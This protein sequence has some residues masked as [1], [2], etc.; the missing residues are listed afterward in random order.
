MT[1]K[2][3]YI[4]Y[5]L[6]TV[7]NSPGSEFKENYRLSKLVDSI[8]AIDDVMKVSYVVGKT[9]GLELLFK[10]LLYI[11]D[12]IDKSQVTIF[13]L[14]D[15]FEYDKIN[16]A[17]ICA[18]I[19]LYKSE[20]VQEAIKEI[21]EEKP[22]LRS[23]EHEKIT[24]EVKD[25]ITI[26]TTEKENVVN[27]VEMEEMETVESDEDSG[28]TGL[29]LIEN[30]ETY[31]GE[32]EV[33]E[34]ESISESVENS[35]KDEESSSLKEKNNDAE[36][37]ESDE[38]TD[39]D[40][41]SESE[42]GGI[43]QEEIEETENIIADIEDDNDAESDENENDET[44]NDEAENVES[45]DLNTI[46]EDL[47]ELEIE[48]HKPM[49]SSQEDEHVKEE[50]ITNDAYYT[51]ETRFFEE[52]KILEKLLAT[53]NRDC[54]TDETGKL[55]EKCLQCLTEI[56]GITSELSNLSRQLSFDLIADIFLTMNIYFTRSISQPEL[57][58]DERI[59]LLDSSLALVNSLI[60]GE[61]YLNYDT[62]VDK[63]EKLKSDISTEREK[64]IKPEP[65]TEEV[66]VSEEELP[67]VKNDEPKPQEQEFREEVYKP[68]ME[69]PA[70]K[71]S[72]MESALFRLKYLIKEFEKSFVSIGNLKGEYSKIEALEKISELNNA[73]RLIAKIAAAIKNNDV[74]KLAEVTYVF[75]KYVKDYRM[76]MQE[77]E[78][79]QIIKYIIFTFKML[80]TD[81][82][83]EDFNVLVQHL[84]NPVKI[85]AD[86]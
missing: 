86:S 45:N 52:V 30:A 7:V 79:Q 29:T 20:N 66:I 42:V 58:T 39:G 40:G 16:I 75:L 85:F 63:I 69:K 48:V 37:T 5:L 46:F 35:D 6:Y 73:L 44:E 59:K 10:Y 18:K 31:T 21:T 83:P 22:D 55:S 23:T 19:N 13:N 15:N 61:D 25:T 3:D 74:L 54:M 57:L 56:M 84:N 76:D 43:S 17:K 68:V 67:E 36:G 27:L 8:I 34:L 72:Q 41:A 81:R 78:V 9:A 49:G 1:F 77:P 28:D 2:K 38:T 60:K 11:S 33:F 80:L 47:P 26:D 71:K 65:E 70:L 14:K 64:E 32:A 51:F 50:A 4:N 82:K 53:V 62:I 24:D 12:K